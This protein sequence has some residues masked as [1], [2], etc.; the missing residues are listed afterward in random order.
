MA[1]VVLAGVSRVYPGGVSAVDCLDLEIRDQELLV[2]VGPSGC[3]KT[4]TLRLIA[5]LESACAGT[6]RIGDRVVN[7]V[8]ARRRNIAM[9]FQSYALY[10]HLTVRGNL[11]FGLKL[12]SAAGL[13]GIWR[14]V[15]QPFGKEGIEARIDERVRKAAAILGIE[16]LLDRRPSELSGGQ[17]Q[18]VALGRAIV[19][20]PEAFLL[21]EP[22]SNLDAQLRVEMRHELKQFHRRLAATMIYVTHDQIEALALADRV[23]VM[24]KGRVRQVGLPQAVYDQPADRFVA[25]FVGSPPMNLVDGRW[26]NFEDE[27]WRNAARRSCVRLPADRRFDVGIRPEHVCLRHEGDEF[28]KLVCE[29]EVQSV[30]PLGDSTIVYLKPFSDGVEKKVWRAE[31]WRAKVGVAAG[32]RPGERVR[33]WF[34]MRR[35]HWFDALTGARLT[36]A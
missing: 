2:L 21:D 6:I 32:P 35:V 22:L 26:V 5:G 8:S 4:T 15:V 28:S 3:G 7:D 13:L 9:V 23:A 25:A 12:R 16:P 17:R 18:R 29:A 36:G 30:E 34:D 10:P 19:H 20:E 27:A 31:V 24:E 33:V 1:S 11:A 14:R